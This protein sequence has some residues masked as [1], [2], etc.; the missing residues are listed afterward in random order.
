MLIIFCAEIDEAVN[1]K[2]PH[3]KIVITGAGLC[4]VIQTPKLNIRPEDKVINIGYAG[5]N[6]YPVGE[7][8]TVGKCRRLIPSLTINEKELIINPLKELTSTCCYTA[9]DF[10]EQDK[11]KEIPLVDMELYYLASIYPQIESIK[12]VSDNLNLT[13]YR[14][15]DLSASWE[16]VNRILNNL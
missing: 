15:A 1:I 5:S 9:D 6:L 2:C 8:R 10:I 12:I 3:A 16:T 4:N 11:I 13:E 7:V 14:K